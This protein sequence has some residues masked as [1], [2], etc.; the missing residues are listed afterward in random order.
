MTEMDDCIIIAI[1]S[2]KILFGVKI[3]LTCETKITMV[4]FKN[5]IG[6]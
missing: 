4:C 1:I 2:I 6:L 5:K 3:V